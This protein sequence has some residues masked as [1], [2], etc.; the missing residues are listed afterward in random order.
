MDVALSISTATTLKLSLTRRAVGTVKELSVKD[1]YVFRNR[2]VSGE[3][4][5]IYY[6][7]MGQNN[8]QKEQDEHGRR[9]DGR[10]PCCSREN[11]TRAC[12]RDEAR[13]RTC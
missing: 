6:T 12:Q 8:P 10:V 5:S 13:W 3:D 2:T 9:G 11:E 7:A 1:V 4:V